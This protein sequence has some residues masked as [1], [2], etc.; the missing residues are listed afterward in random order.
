MKELMYLQAINE[1]IDEEMNKDEKVFVIGEDVQAAT[2]GITRGLV[3]KYGPDRIIDTPISETAIAGAAVGAAMTGFRPIADL[4]FADFMFVAGDEI[5]N[6]AAKWRFI[7]GGSQSLPMVIMAAMGGYTMN[8]AEHSQS[9]EAYFMHTP[10]LK[11]VVPSTPYDAKGLMKTAIRDNN[12]VIY[13]F[14][15][16]LLGMQG[17]VP[18]EEYTIPFGVADIKR[19]GTDVT[20]VATSRM[21]HLSMGVAEEMKDK[22]SIEVIDPRTL[23]PLDIGTILESVKKTGRCVIVDED[24]S[25][26]GPAAEIAMQIMEQAFDYLDAPIQRVCALNYPIPGGYM[27]SFVLP[28]PQGVVAAIETVMG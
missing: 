13:L 9:P 5:F 1:A 2:F 22:V 7:H 28:Q 4:Y 21:V 11:V 14:H 25:R 27:E 18:E 3:Q 19:E 26:C 17:E 10:G 12:P 24:T 6:K 15:K 16:T 8:G 23:E 20:V